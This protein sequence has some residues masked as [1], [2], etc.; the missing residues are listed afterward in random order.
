MI[1]L[2]VHAFFFLSQIMLELLEIPRREK[3]RRG[4][5]KLF[6]Y[7]I[8]LMN[9]VFGNEFFAFDFANKTGG[10]TQ[11]IGNTALRYIEFL[12]FFPNFIDDV[13]VNR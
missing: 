8:K 6:C 2:E 13:Q 12:P 9:A 5:F 1:F 10:A 4:T 11:Y 3:F 7:Q